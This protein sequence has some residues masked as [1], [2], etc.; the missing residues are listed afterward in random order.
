MRSRL[1]L[2]LSLAAIAAALVSGV[3]S[4]G[5]S[6]DAQ[7]HSYIGPIDPDAALPRIG[8]PPDAGDGG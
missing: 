2:A 1:V 3:L 6:D 4:V 8:P 5:C 7:T